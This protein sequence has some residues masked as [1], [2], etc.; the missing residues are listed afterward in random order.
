MATYEYWQQALLGNFLPVHEDEPQLGFWRKRTGKAAGYIPVA[1]W[2]SDSGEIIALVDGRRADNASDVWTYICQ[3][4]ITEQQY[5]DRVVTGKWWDQDD[6]VTASLQPPPAGHNGPPTDPAEV[7]K[8]SIETALKGVDDY[9]KVDDDAT[10]AKAQS[11]RSRLLELRGDADK[12]REALV[13]PHLD[14]QNATNAVWMPIVKAAKA[15]ADKI[16]LALGAHETR[17]DLAAKAEAKKAEDA[18]RKALEDAQAHAPIGVTIEPEPAPPPPKAAPAPIKGAY[19]RAGT[20]KTIKVAT[21]TDQDAAYNFLKAQPELVEIIQT[22]AQKMVTNGF[23]VPG[24]SVEE[25][26]K[27]V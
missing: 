13:R 11:L 25:Q 26:K 15:G 23:S 27:V 10:A 18:R 2:L 14:A 20:V 4:P 16:A 3:H 6:S 7:L 17:K 9:A 12:K 24:V 1:T 8:E 21:V 19:G 22:L 5:K